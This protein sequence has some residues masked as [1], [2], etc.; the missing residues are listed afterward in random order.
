MSVY[1]PPGA[2]HNCPICH[3]VNRAGAKF[4]SKCG[5][6]LAA[7]PLP[8]PTPSYP[9]PQAAAYTPPA[10]TPPGQNTPPPHVSSS[11]PA[12]SHMSLDYPSA[13]SVHSN[14]SYPTYNKS[15][16]GINLSQALG[17]P[18]QSNNWLASLIIGGILFVVPLGIIFLGGFYIDVMRRIV[19]DD[20]DPMPAW[21][22]WGKKFK[23]GLI[24]FTLTIIYVLLPMIVA[25]LPGLLV[26]LAGEEETGLIISLVGAI[27]GTLLAYLF[28]PL[29][30][31]QYVESDRF[32]EGLNV[33]K[34]SKRILSNPLRYLGN[35]AITFF[36]L[37]VGIFVIS[38]VNAI[39]TA[40]VVGL[41]CTIPITFVVSFY[42]TLYQYNLM[43]QLYKTTR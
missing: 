24:L 15:Q 43:A 9:P 1:T 28:I 27:L 29:A 3:T 20:P 14:P 34:L 6:K 35:C 2:T 19:N 4:C 38:I 39:G 25:Y 12:P 26:T 31:G 16:S 5:S 41:L 36:A 32:V 33:A 11:P 13:H 42:L 18:F 8:S 7:A 21:N 17:F 30:L 40:L 10:Y 37:F 23:D 22:E